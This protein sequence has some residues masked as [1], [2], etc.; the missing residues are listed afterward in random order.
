MRQNRR[1]I[2][3]TAGAGLGAISVAVSACGQV[4]QQSTSTAIHSAAGTAGTSGL[5]SGWRSMR[6]FDVHNHVMYSVHEPDADWSRVE[7]LI[8][9][10]EILGIERLCCSRPISGGVMAE[11][12]DV[13]SAN[14]SVLAAMK[15]YP[16]R[17]SGFCFVQPGNGPAALEEIERCLAG[18]MIG[19]KLY[20]QFRYT[21]P[22]VFPI[23]ERCIDRRIP[24]LG[25]SAHLTDAKSIAAQPKTSDSLDFCELS[26]RYPE[27]MLILGHINGGGDWEWAIKG[28][29]GCSNVYLDTSGSVLEQDTIEM[30]VRELG[31]ERLLFATDMTME[32][33]V[34]KILSAELTPDQRED[35]FWR[36]LQRI[37]DR[38]TA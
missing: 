20:N 23:A 34:G 35:I 8:E 30:C 36:N 26:M 2:L 10:A 7:N 25:H 31:H 16:E 21:D 12:A 37:L 29:R 13:R 32:G 3:K 33:C 18:G 28:L 6:K 5:P 4:R 9:A 24:F 14:D 11:I 38:R 1:G 22:M 15:R 27:L 19:V 17:I